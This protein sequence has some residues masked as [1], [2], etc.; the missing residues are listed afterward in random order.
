MADQAEAPR[1]SVVT[2]APLDILF[3][4]PGITVEQVSFIQRQDLFFKEDQ[5]GSPPNLRMIVSY[6][7]ANPRTWDFNQLCGASN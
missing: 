3:E 2:T 7:R 6:P 1:D 4:I 5:C